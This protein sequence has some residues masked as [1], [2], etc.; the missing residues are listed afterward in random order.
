MKIYRSGTK[1]IINEGNIAA[2]VTAVEISFES[3]TYK[4]TFFMND[5]FKTVWLNESFFKVCD[6]STKQT[7][8]F[9]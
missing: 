1:V 4:L 5:D 8:G 2:T 7:I 9:K 6:A 3:V